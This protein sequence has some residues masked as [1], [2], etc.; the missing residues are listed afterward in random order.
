[1]KRVWAMLLIVLM[2][3]G[4]SKIEPAPEKTEEKPPVSVEQAVPEPEPEPAPG[5]EPEPEIEPV[6][7]PAP[8]PIPQPQPAPPPDWCEKAMDAYVAVTERDQFQVLVREA[9][10][11]GMKLTIVQGKNDWNVTF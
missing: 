1:M 7:E 2:L 4:C 6:P 3:M 5:P 8:A 9:E 10:G 11:A